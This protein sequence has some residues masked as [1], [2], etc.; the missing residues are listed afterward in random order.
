MARRVKDGLRWLIQIGAGCVATAIFVIVGV[1]W[2]RALAGYRRARDKPPRVMWGPMPVVNV[3]YTAQASRAVGYPS[4][5][6]VYNVYSINRRSDFDRVLDRY[7]RVPL[8][9]ELTPFAAFVGSAF[10]YDAFGF[11]YDGGLLWATPFWRL[12]LALLDLAGKTILVYP[13]G[14]DARLPSKTRTRGGWHAYSEIPVGEEDR[15]EREVVRRLTAFARHADLMLGCADLYQDLPRCDGMMRYAF[16]TTGW[17]P[18]AI[19][20]SHVV[21]V[22]H[23]PNHRHYKGTRHLVDAV[24]RLRREGI[25]LE[26]VLVEG[27]PTD[28]ARSYYAR[29]DIVAD[30]F[31]IG[32][33]ALL[34][35]EGMALGKPVVCYLNPRFFSAHPEWAECPIVS[36]SPTELVDVLR[37][38]ALD[39]ERRRTLGARGP[40]YVRK[41]HSL[42][43][44]GAD[45]DR[46]FRQTWS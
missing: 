19:E 33:Y 8:L 13:Y 37:A 30:Q 7:A 12:E 15:D 26:L 39:A 20:T 34:A 45:L 32:A 42:E 2:S 36:A 40:D 41:F 29:A 25:P 27:M 18:A 4:D 14:S 44:I 31:L 23:A 5:S 17:Q 10:R 22:V 1:P 28:E 9:R 21:R 6:L 16:D 43:S 3:R 24:E 46:W 38:L 35:I 11:F